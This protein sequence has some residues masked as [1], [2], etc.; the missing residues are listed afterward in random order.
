MGRGYRGWALNADALGDK[1]LWLYYTDNP[2]IKTIK[3]LFPSGR[4]QRKNFKN[5]IL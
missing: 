3:Y 1:T 5:I 4:W 2:I